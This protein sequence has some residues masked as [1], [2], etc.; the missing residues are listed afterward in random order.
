M[1]GKNIKFKNFNLKKNKF[2]KKKQIFNIYE[3]L[4]KEKNEVIL[5][6]D[7][8]YKDTFT[9]KIVKKLKKINHILLIG[10]G[11]SILGAKAIYKF[12]NPKH[13]KF[14][15]IDNF[16]NIPL[17]IDNK[18]KITLIISKSGNTLETISNSNILIN[19]KKQKFF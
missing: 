17:R 4:I 15:F 19:K 9:K 10:M 18:K 8:N 6:L 2:N 16:S 12:L 1:F 11:G 3:N 5:S 13:K 14:I 7:K